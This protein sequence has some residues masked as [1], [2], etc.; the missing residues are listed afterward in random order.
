VADAPVVQALDHEPV[1]LTGVTDHQTDWLDGDKDTKDTSTDN[2][3]ANG[4]SI[5]F[6][7]DASR[8]DTFLSQG[9]PST[10]RHLGTAAALDAPAKRITPAKVTNVHIGRDGASFDVDRV[11]APVLVKISYFPNWKASGATGPYRVT[12]NLMLVVP[13]SKHVELSYGREPVDLISI[14]MSLLGIALAIFLARRPPVPM[15]V[16]VRREIMRDAV[17]VDDDD[18]SE[19]GPWQERT[20]VVEVG[21]DDR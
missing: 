16:R 8:W 19:R 10:W 14:A 3:R 12:P 6:F 13:T 15:P 7:Q 2:D 4:P 21:T 11:G 17:V 1:V 18:A 5:Q 9:G 20:S